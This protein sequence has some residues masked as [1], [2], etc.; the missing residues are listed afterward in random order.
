MT[1]WNEE[2][3]AWEYQ[4]TEERTFREDER[5]SRYGEDGGDDREEVPFHIPRD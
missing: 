3:P 2:R 5:P 4:P 1:D